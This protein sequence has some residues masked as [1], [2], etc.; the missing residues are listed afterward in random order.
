MIDSC[1]IPMKHLS[2]RGTVHILSSR[3]GLVIGADYV[4]MPKHDGN[5]ITGVQKE[6]LYSEYLIHGVKVTALL[7]NYVEV[8]TRQG[9]PRI[10]SRCEMPKLVEL[11]SSRFVSRSEHQM[12]ILP[13]RV[14][15]GYLQVG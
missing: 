9:S 10:I 12:K 8:V 4:Y 1:L 15:Q 6:Q 3:S 11:S 13:A 7:R 2:V 14:N 5:I